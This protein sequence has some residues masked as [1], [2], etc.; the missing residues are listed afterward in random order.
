MDL[1]DAHI[2]Y[3]LPNL[4]LQSKDIW[5]RIAVIYHHKGFVNRQSVQK[6]VILKGN[7]D[8]S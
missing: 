5:I 7:L 4:Y 8:Y 3:C 6:L 1:S 2:K